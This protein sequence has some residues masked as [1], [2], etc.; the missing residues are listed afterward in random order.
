MKT[1][2]LWKAH[3]QSMNL[4]ALQQDAV[5]DV[6]I[7]GGGITGISIADALCREGIKVLVL[8]ARKICG[9][10][11]S[12]ST[13]N[14][15]ETIDSNLSDLKQKWDI[16]VVKQVLA[17]RRAAVD[18]IEANISAHS[19]DCDFERAPWNFYAA[20]DEAVKTID[21]EFETG[22]EVGLALERS[23]LGGAPFNAKTSITL[24]NQAQFNPMR[25][26]QGLARAVAER[27]PVYENTRVVEIEEDGD[28]YT[29]TTPHGRV[30]ANYVVHATHTPKGFMPLQ[31]M[32]GPYREYGIACKLTGANL[33]TGIYWGLFEG[34]EVFSSRRYERDGQ[35]YLVVVGQ[36][37][38]VGQVDNNHDKIATLEW[39][40]REHFAV[41][42]I[43]YRWGG[44]H[45]R[46]ADLIPYIGRKSHNSNILVATGFSTDGLTWGT[47][48]STIITDQ[49]VGRHNPYSE[50]FSPSRV[51]P[52]KSA[53][54][55]L[56]EN[57]NV[58]KQYLKNLPG[59]GDM[60]RFSD[61]ETG[62]GKIV[63]EDGK[64]LAV[65]RA[66]DGRLR[67]CSAVCTH[68]G[69]IVSWN[70]AEATWDCPCHGSR[71]AC[72]G[73]VIEGPAL[74]PLEA[75]TLD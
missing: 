38:K 1:D 57:L 10:T 14:L 60:S 54:R 58:A 19:I 56:K 53:P 61:V 44:Q 55:F 34:E 74:E 46:P 23:G 65:S 69:C 26:G 64:K 16:D 67:V 45:Y 48:A 71:F 47:I 62:M 72:D 41:E 29:L 66:E 7:I 22:T 68:L 4:P 2:S 3:G 33:P 75:I 43:T 5:C 73:S 17:S 59:T 27:C 70:D 52:V 28:T 13:G 50:T 18:R 30:R 63:E 42:E 51:T 15:Y 24:P 31:T 11:T 9:G 39:F 49:I 40:A 35:S 12:H 6:A 25:Y 21:K 20:V 36:P 37:H 8:E 32:L